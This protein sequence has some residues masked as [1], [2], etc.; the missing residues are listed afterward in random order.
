MEKGLLLA[1]SS[2]RQDVKH[3]ELGEV[4]H[5][6]F[7]IKKLGNGE[8]FCSAHFLLYAVQNFC[9]GNGVTQCVYLFNLN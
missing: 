4:G 3:G 1:S 7:I 9:T 6:V 8:F 2:R 5:I